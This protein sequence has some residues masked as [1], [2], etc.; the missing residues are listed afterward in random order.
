V[1][2]ARLFLELTV[3]GKRTLYAVTPHAPHPSIATKAWRLRNGK[4][5]YDVSIDKNG[6]PSCTCAS[7]TFKTHGRCKH[8]L[9][10]TALGLMEAK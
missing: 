7:S 2:T 8:Y 4:R 1:N 3:K 6:W 5:V 9:A 10:L